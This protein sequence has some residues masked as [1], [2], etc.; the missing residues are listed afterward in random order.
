MTN[1]VL[2]QPSRPRR[3]LPILTSAAVVAIP[4][5]A[6]AAPVSIPN[7]FAEGDIVS[8]QDFND[9][10]EAIAN[11]INDNDARIAALEAAPFAVPE[12][13]I[14]KSTGSLERAIAFCEADEILAGG[15]CFMP[16]SNDY[17]PANADYDTHFTGA[18]P[19]PL[20]GMTSVPVAPGTSLDDLRPTATTGANIIPFP[21]DIIADD[22]G[23]VAA[24]SGGGWGCRAG[25]VQH[26]AAAAAQAITTNLYEEW[27]YHVKSYAVCMRVP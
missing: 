18:Y 24:T 23:F 11:A 25:I 15:G 21:G 9:N 3:R 12:I 14:R 26:D 5:L 7:Q 16:P 8:A 22:S 4:V 6:I 27:F 20:V 19:R 2:L 10:F 17:D 13:T 1:P